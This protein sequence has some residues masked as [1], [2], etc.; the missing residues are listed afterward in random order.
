MA[1]A[2][3]V[4]GYLLGSVPFGLVIARARGLDIRQHGSGNIGATN[5]ARNLG[6]KLG[7]VVLLLD[8][9]KGALPVL[10]AGLLDLDPPVIAAAGGAAI[11]GHCFPVW[12]RF[13]GGKGVATS[14]GAFLSIDP[15]VT[16]L[17]VLAFALIVG[18]TRM[19]SLGSLVGMGAFPVAALALGRPGTTIALGVAAWLVIAI[20]HR[21]NLSRIVRGTEHRF[22]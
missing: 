19:V 8:A 6:K 9:L 5:V 11:L 4:A 7:A 22:R 1:V 3:I 17:G 15:T 14:L 13:R 12:L 16:G 10:G 2:A 21:E 20:Q 18:A